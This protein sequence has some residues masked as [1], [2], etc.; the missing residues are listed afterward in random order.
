M[1]GKVASINKRR[2]MILVD[3]GDS[4]YTWMELLGEYDVDIGDIIEGALHSL[5]GE[6]VRNVS[7][8]EQMSVYIQDI[9]M[10]KA[11]GLKMI[12]K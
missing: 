9:H 3:D 4:E 2:G 11:Y 6:T 5:G 10:T 12:A 1:R 8:R 7:K